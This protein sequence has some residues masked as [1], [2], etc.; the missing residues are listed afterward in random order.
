MGMRM[1]IDATHLEETRVVVVKGTRLEE[2]DYE[3]STKQVLKGNIYLARVTRVEPSLQAAFVEY[4]GN[5]HGFLAFGEIHPDYYQIPIA[6]REKLLAQQAEEDARAAAEEEAEL[7]AAEERAAAAAAKGETVDEDADHSGVE[8][9]DGDYDTVEEISADMPLAD[10]P[11]YWNVPADAAST[12]PT[13]SAEAETD[14][15]DH[16]SA[17]SHD[18]DDHRG[19]DD[20]GSDDQDHDDHGEDDHDS[21]DHGYDDHG[22]DSHDDDEDDGDDDDAGSDDAGDDEGVTGDAGESGEEAAAAGAGEGAEER[23]GDNRRGGQRGRG[24]GRGRGRSGSGNGNGKG[25]STGNGGRS[26]DR[27]ERRSRRTNVFRRYKIQEVIKRRQIMLVQ[28]VKEERGNKGAALTTYLSLA[29]RYCV[30]MPNTARGGGIS[31]KIQS[32]AD[33][34]R[35]KAITAELDI[36]DGMGVIVRTAGMERSKPEIKRDFEYLLRSWDSIRERTRI[37]GADPDLRGSRPDQ[38]V[39]PRSL[40]RPDR[41]CAGRGRA[42][43]EVRA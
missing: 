19:H 22:G 29:G 42:G 34:K 23:G 15:A 31:R 33:R 21:D 24:R 43:L 9:V 20:H 10:A 38:A 1:L 13:V 27:E 25:S 28:V 26:D 4:G 2:F 30:L 40:L 3:A 36:P 6:D 32:Q 16:T 37:V 14:D 41:R 5:R 18:D 17:G 39:D 11:A 12:V 8:T 35:L 7:D